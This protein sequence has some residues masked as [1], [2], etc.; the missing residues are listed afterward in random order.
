[1]A[2]RSC[3]CRDWSKIANYAFFPIWFDSQ[4]KEYFLY[5]KNSAD[6]IVIYYC[7]SCGGRIPKPRLR[8]FF[9]IGRR[10]FFLNP[11]EDEMAEARSLLEGILDTH[12]MRSVLGEPDEVFDIPSDDLN[13]PL[14]VV[15]N[16]KIKRQYNYTSRWKTLRIGIQETEDGHLTTFFCGKDKEI[17]KP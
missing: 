16:F 10:E 6:N 5:G 1:M 17:D 11:S 3:T 2:E 14:R 8:K 7:P 13:D 12:T 15:R 9:K 4:V